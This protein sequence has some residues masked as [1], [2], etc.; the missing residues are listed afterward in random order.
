MVTLPKSRL[1]AFGLLA[2]GL[3]IT[4]LSSVMAQEFS[5]TA[6]DECSPTAHLTQ[7]TQSRTFGMDLL[8]GDYSVFA[9]E[10]NHGGVTDTGKLNALGFN[11]N[12]RFVYG[13]SY[14]HRQPVRVHK[15][16]SVELFSADANITNRDFYV[17][18]VSI[19]HNRYY[20]Y[21]R[22]GVYGL[23]YF[24]LDPSKPDY[25][26][27]T[28]VPGSN[29]MD[30][31]IADMAFH[32][33]N[34]LAYAIDRNGY[35]H[36]INPD[37]GSSEKQG[38]T[39]ITGTFGAAYF[40]VEGNLYVS[41]NSDGKIFRLGIDAGETEAQ[42]FAAGPSS[43]FNDGFRCAI[44]GVQVNTANLLDFG[45]A[46]DSYGTTIESNG[47][48]HGLGSTDGTRAVE[49]K[50]SVRLGPSVDGES[51]AYA[52]PLSDSKEGNDEDGVK[53]INNIVQ[54]QSARVA[55]S[56]PEGGYLNVWLDAN[57]NGAFDGSDHV[58]TDQLLNPG[59]QTVS[60]TVPS[61]VVEGD[62]WARFRISSLPGLEATGGAPDGEVEDY[63]V[64]LMADPVTVAT[65]P[66]RSGW[67][68]IAF[69]DNWPFVG[70]YD[71]NDVVTQLRTY[72]Y[73]DSRG[74]TKVDIVGRVNASGAFYENGFGIRLPGVY[75]DAIDEA[76]VEFSL[77]D[78][79]TKVN[80]LEPN[81]KEAIFL[82]TDNLF[83]HVA[84]GPDCS[85]YRTEPGCGA[86]IEFYFKLSI[87]FNEP[88]SVK[89]SGVFDPFIYATPGAFHGE[90]FKT[91]PGR[92]YEIHMKNQSPTE[93]F[94]RSLFGKV[95]QDR[96]APESGTYFLT[97]N[98]MPW[99]LEM[100]NDWL[101][102]REWVEISK[103]YPM[104]RE[105]AT[106]NGTTNKDWYLRDNAVTELV[107]TE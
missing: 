42:F 33:F 29:S 104:F 56:A 51:D 71:M 13:W 3:N 23:Y 80:P 45:D 107:Y 92:S 59:E 72:T 16:W 66:S 28:R 53:F 61:N 65:Y 49:S 9:D 1:I 88:Q 96:S 12:D 91:P 67:S 36:V 57:R 26:E 32:P 46:P 18:D 8:T 103:A 93:A 27:M 10:H 5:A 105:W 39:G 47:A 15:D 19:T 98:G 4:P 37:T 21:R 81:R 106:S 6:F 78:R 7:G 95:G 58:I 41:N 97:E 35:L 34:G 68:T 44:A 64:K 55:V 94:D 14:T 48:R 79:N 102:P 85:F 69:E 100:G 87:P 50:T 17:G 11:P 74:F 24:E 70:D 90:H 99:V 20:V 30:L 31:R 60:F 84:A 25:L 63:P 52:Y 75:R 86:D 54:H 2:A 77:S 89:L 43:T 82:I 101:Y 22:G 40:D 38:N 73:R 83:N 62:S 76:N